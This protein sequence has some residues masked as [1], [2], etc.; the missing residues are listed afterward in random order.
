MGHPHAAD[1]GWTM[2]DTG[3]SHHIQDAREDRDYSRFPMV[4]LRL[5]VG[6]CQAYQINDDVLVM[7]YQED[8]NK[9]ETSFSQSLY[10]MIL[11]SFRQI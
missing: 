8:P 11:H 9:I 7:P 10:V 6:K 4:T 3:A 5:A 1:T 2:L